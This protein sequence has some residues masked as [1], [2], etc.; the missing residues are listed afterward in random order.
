M[1]NCCKSGD[2]DDYNDRHNRSETNRV[3]EHVPKE[4]G[5]SIAD[6]ANSTD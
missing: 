6:G 2:V 1:T 4:P 3:Q 5:E